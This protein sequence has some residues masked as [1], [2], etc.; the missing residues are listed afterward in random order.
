MM[1]SRFSCTSCGKCCFGWLPL[2]LEDALTHAGRFPLAFIWSVVPPGTRNHALAKQLGVT[3][4]S[5]RRIAVVIMPTAYIPSALPC[6]ELSTEGLCRIHDSK[7]SRCKTMPFYPYREESDQH[8]LLMP[9]KDWLCDIT[10]A[11]QVAYRDGK[12]LARQ[13]FE[14]ER[15]ALL[16]QSDIMRQYADYMFKYSPWMVDSLNALASTPDGTLLTSLSSFLTAI[17]H[18]DSRSI[19][20][21]QLPVF[22]AFADKTKGTPELAEYHKHYTGWAKEMNYLANRAMARAESA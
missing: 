4:K 22:M 21:Q 12:I 17:K 19:A 13:D 15:R 3:L 18:L 2:T 7:P 9:R 1:E 5:G 11:A 6:P 14:L 10:P 16:A 8:A 20:A